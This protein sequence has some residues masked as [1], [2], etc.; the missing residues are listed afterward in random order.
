MRHR[1]RRG[2]LAVVWVLVAG[3]FAPQP[4]MF[5]DGEAVPEEAFRVLLPVRP[6]PDGTWALNDPAAGCSA[7]AAL[8]S[9]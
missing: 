6:G 5:G 1:L 4:P 9:V 7:R 2:L 8:W 3:C